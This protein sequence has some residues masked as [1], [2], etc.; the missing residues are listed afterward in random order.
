M[1][2]SGH[3]LCL[4]HLRVLCLTLIKTTLSPGLTENMLF[5]EE[6]LGLHEI[7]LFG[8]PSETFIR[9]IAVMSSLALGRVL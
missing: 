2:G 9:V 7:E 5:Y 3:S 6:A 1:C 8:I 4:R